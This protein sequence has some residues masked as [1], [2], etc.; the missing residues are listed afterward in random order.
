MT[1]RFLPRTELAAR[2][3]AVSAT[4]LSLVLC[5]VAILM[6]QL[7][8]IAS[9]VAA[10]IAAAAVIAF[11]SRL[12]PQRSRSDRTELAE[13]REKFASELEA[14]LGASSG[15]PPDARDP[16]PD[17]DVSHRQARGQS[18][19]VAPRRALASRKARLA[20][21]LVIASTIA[22]GIA[23]SQVLKGGR[24]VPAPSASTIET[25]PT[26][27]V[28]AADAEARSPTFFSHAQ[29]EDALAGELGECEPEAM[30]APEGTVP[31][32]VYGN[33]YLRKAVVA[34]LL[35][36]SFNGKRWI[37]AANGDAGVRLYEWGDR[38]L[39]AESWL[40]QRRS[41]RWAPSSDGGSVGGFDQARNRLVRM[42]VVCVRIRQH[43]W[44]LDVDRSGPDLVVRGSPPT[45]PAPSE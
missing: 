44:L 35:R 16:R 37:Q 15:A 36:N 25:V 21:V 22:T 10:A 7:H 9:A 20:L 23:Y 45:S 12:P 29:Y 32:S 40:E 1:R 24:P 13:L 5:V 6:F 11:R 14:R 4:A 17:V 3:V 33:A 30:L 18:P 42:C 2:V 41:G 27:D 26:T 31:F 19:S 28:G 34:V 38:D 39:T 8:A 43:G